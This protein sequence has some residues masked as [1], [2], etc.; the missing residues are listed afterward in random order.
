MTAAASTCAVSW[1]SSS[2]AS[3]PLFCVRISSLAPSC[4]GAVRSR[5]CPSTLTASAARARPAPIAAAA[6]APVA[7]SSSWSS[8]PSGRRAFIGWPG[9]ANAPLVTGP[10]APDGGASPT[11]LS[12]IGITAARRTPSWAPRTAAGSL[13]SALS[14]VSTQGVAS[15]AERELRGARRKV[16]RPASEDRDPRLDRVRR[17]RLHGRQHGRHQAGQRP[18]QRHRRVRSRRARP[19]RRLPAAVGRDGL[20]PVAE[21]DGERPAVQSR[22]RPTSS[23]GWRSCRRSRASPRRT[24]RATAGRSRPT[25][26]PRSSRSR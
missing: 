22:G 8:V 4:S 20:R 21:A 24:P 26:M 15:N 11:P 19:L 14:H 6:S 12:G 5:S 2:S 10:T 18:R 3:S 16:E 25:V 9:Y 1:R 17:R 7:P 23:R 13:L